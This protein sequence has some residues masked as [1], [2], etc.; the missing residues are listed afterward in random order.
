M[1][2]LTSCV[3]LDDL[4]SLHL[5]ISLD[6]QAGY[7]SLNT[8]RTTTQATSFF[9]KIYIHCSKTLRKNLIVT[10]PSWLNL[11]DIKDR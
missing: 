3:T 9:L 6:C 5:H 11:R 1:P 4:T 2:N 7:T 10:V 8:G